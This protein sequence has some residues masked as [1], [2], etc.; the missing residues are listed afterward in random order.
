M[1]FLGYC[2]LQGAERGYLTNKIVKCDKLLADD[3]R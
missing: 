3:P 1:Y 2:T